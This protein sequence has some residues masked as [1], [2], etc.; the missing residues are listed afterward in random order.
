M[1]V[2]SIIRTL[3]MFS[4]LTTLLLYKNSCSV[5][6]TVNYDIRKQRE[7]RRTGDYMQ[8]TLDLVN[9]FQQQFRF[10]T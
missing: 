7:A 9:C 6:D 4:V 3:L 8:T 2:F 10:S 5:K 1:S